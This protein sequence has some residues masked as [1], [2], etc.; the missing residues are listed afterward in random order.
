MPDP[1]PS[2]QQ[3]CQSASRRLLE[4]IPSLRST[5]AL[6]GLDGFVDEIIE[7]VDTRQDLT[8]YQRIRTIDQ[9]GRKFVNAAG[10]SSNYEMV[11]KQMKLGGNGPIMANALAKAGLSVTY[12]GALGYPNP[13]PVF[14]TLG[15]DA[16]VI[17]VGDPGHTDA[18]EFDDGKIML[19]KLTCFDELNWDTLLARVGADRL[20]AL[21]ERS[22]LVGMTNWT[23]L[24]HLSQIWA[25]LASDVL[26]KASRGPRKRI[27]FADLADP[28]KKTRQNLRE[29]MDILGRMQAGSGVDVILGLNLK[30]SQQVAEVM[31]VGQTGDS[32]AIIE[33]TARQIRQAM[34]IHCVVIHPRSVAAAATANES[35]SFQGPF[36]QQPR[37][38]TGA[39][40]HFNAGFCLGRIAGMS[41]VESLC[42]G[43]ASSGYYVRS[44]ES[45]SA[46][47]LAAFMAELPSPQGADPAGTR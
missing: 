20:L 12:V 8:H 24:P 38:S 23:M 41:L 11:V 31:G 22:T 27:F 14:E 32:E 13:H 7:V 21:V 25:R 17:S 30:E 4:M 40:D 44:A 35:A 9:L 47:K 1:V 19:G 28:E 29:A 16:E 2:R 34:N 39:G 42:T 18:L 36:V 33:Q 46:E 37:I 3:V 43:T 5:R 45:P 6:I 26:P 15:R 10:Q